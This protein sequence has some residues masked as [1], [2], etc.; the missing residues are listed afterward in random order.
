MATKKELENR[1]HELEQILQDFNSISGYIRF[2]S[3]DGSSTVYMDYYEYVYWHKRVT[4][5]IP[6]FNQGRFIIR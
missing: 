3:V 6:E 5:L 2:N 1:I 4:K